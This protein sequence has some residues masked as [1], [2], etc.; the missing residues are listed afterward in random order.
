MIRFED[1]HTENGD[2][3]ALQLF[4]QF[5]EE[6]TGLPTDQIKE[7]LS[8]LLVGIVDE[9]GGEWAAE[10]EDQA[11][12]HLTDIGE[13]EMSFWDNR[14]NA[15]HFIRDYLSNLSEQKTRPKIK[16]RKDAGGVQ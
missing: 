12:E 4:I 7:K 1:I 10:V 8:Y 15:Q 2:K 16:L 3:H 5:L 11:Q 13:E 9:Y 6:T 14:P